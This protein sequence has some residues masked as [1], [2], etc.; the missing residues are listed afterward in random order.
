MLTVSI[1]VCASPDKR[2]EATGTTLHQLRRLE[3][4]I[5]G[6]CL[7]IGACAA[8]RGGESRP[9]SLPSAGVRESAARSDAGLHRKVL[10]VN[11]G[12]WPPVACVA[13]R[14]GRSIVVAYVNEPT[15]RD[16]EVHVNDSG[17][18]RLWVGRL[19]DTLELS[20]SFSLDLLPVYG[21]DSAP[22]PQ[23][24]GLFR[25]SEFAAVVRYVATVADLDLKPVQETWTT[26]SFDTGRVM[27]TIRPVWRPWPD[28]KVEGLQ[29][30]DVCA[31]EG[32]PLHL[33]HWVV[34]MPSG[35]LAA[36]VEIAD[37]AGRAYWRRIYDDAYPLARYAS[38]VV[39][40]QLRGDGVQIGS[41]AIAAAQVL[42]RS[43]GI[44]VDLRVHRL[45][46]D[47]QF[48]V[49]E[50]MSAISVSGGAECYLDDE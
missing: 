26:V 31:I 27:G 46:A 37:L 12:L 13:N 19:S 38:D 20:H 6:M 24:R 36:A 18:L 43:R 50:E 22:V 32:T 49:V 39:S 45:A 34:Q 33:L 16:L 40:S 48:R 14:R 41:G 47:A 17:T 23:F 25:S 15:D 2:L 11:G 30:W 9:G 10:A 21:I 42:I 35:S 44:A 28:A 7:L 29:L 3:A 4:W 1:G 5:A 8:P